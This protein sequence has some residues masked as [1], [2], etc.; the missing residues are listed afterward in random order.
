MRSMI[1]GLLVAL[2]VVTGLTAGEA[3]HIRVFSAENVDGKITPTTIQK[4]FE[5]EGFMVEANNDMLAPFK[6]D[7]KVVHHK[8][9]N[10][11]VLWDKDTFRKIGVKYPNFALFTP[12]SMSIYTEKDGTTI[13]VSS[14]S[15]AGIA[16]M[17]GVPAD[18]ADLVNLGKKIEKA[19]KAAMPKGKFITMPYKMVKEE[20]E[21][22]HSVS[23]EVK[24]GADWED[25]KDDLEM[26]FEGKLAP[27]GFV[28]P[29]FVDLNYDLDEH[30]IDA[31]KFFDAYS[32]CKIP[33]I[34]TVSQKHPEAGAVAP[35][36]MYLYM[37]KDENTI[38]MAFPTVYKW[39]SA[40]YIKD[41][42]SR[43]VLL[44]AQKKFETIL[45]ELMAGK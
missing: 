4:A 18:N 36:T 2:L 25:T 26:A 12:L 29:A 27:N 10:L 44:D 5:K 8:V 38:H 15:P 14:M 40:M 32:I 30:D 23:I 39:L 37:K 11:M 19:L 45:K 1:K 41:K 6:R 13:N 3:N 16:Q 21:L 34:Y 35:C 7:F 17:T 22:V 9:Y 20:G 31:Y 24:K 28:S 42:P 33:V 43:D